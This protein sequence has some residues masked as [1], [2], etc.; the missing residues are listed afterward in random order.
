MINTV[1]GPICCRI[2]IINLILSAAVLPNGESV[3]KFPQTLNSV[4]MVNH[5]N[6]SYTNNQTHYLHGVSLFIIFSISVII[7]SEE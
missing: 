5:I 3:T 1:I 6:R 4:I 7:F 2:P